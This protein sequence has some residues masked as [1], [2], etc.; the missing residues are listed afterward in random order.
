MV[1][2]PGRLKTGIRVPIFWWAFI[3]DFRVLYGEINDV[4][5]SKSLRVFSVS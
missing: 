4:A 1:L 2:H 5:I 3:R